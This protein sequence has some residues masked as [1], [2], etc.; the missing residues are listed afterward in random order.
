MAK[1]TTARRAEIGRER[2]ARMRNRLIEAAA[3]VIASH[4]S[5]SVSIDMFIRAAGVARGTFYNH[6]KTREEL[7]DALWTSIGHDPFLEIQSACSELADPAERFAAVTRLV[8]LRAAYEPTWG[9]LIVALSADEAT[10]NDDLRGYPRPDLRAGEAAG[11][12]RYESEASATDLVVG[13]MRAG[14]RALLQEGRAP[15]YAQAL[16]K[17]ILLALGL[18]RI[19]A[20][21]I[22]ALSLPTLWDEV[23]KKP[24]RVP[25]LGDLRPRS[26]KLGGERKTL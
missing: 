3:R 5:D 18:N 4:G 11:R 8:L 26:K 21:R 16:C 1:Q 6:F 12:F 25:R 13:T 2:R 15:N 7:L 24:A 23:S 19:E 20:N 22:S 17:M 10:L 9:W 14:L